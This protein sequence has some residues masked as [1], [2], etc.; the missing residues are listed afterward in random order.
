VFK[1]SLA[2]EMLFAYFR[3]KFT[4]GTDVMILKEK[5]L[6]EKI[7]EQMAFFTQNTNKLCQNGIITLHF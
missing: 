7:G 1:N 3:G 6:P 5:K 2:V 4:A